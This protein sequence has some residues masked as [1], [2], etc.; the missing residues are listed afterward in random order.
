MSADPTISVVIP[1]YNAARWIGET[2]ESVLAQTYQDFEVIV[3]DDGSTDETAAVVGEF[4]GRVRCIQQPNRGQ[5]SARNAGIRAARGE[6][7]AFLDADDLWL[8]EKLH[9]QVGLLK[10]S[11][12]AWVYSDAIAFDNQTGRVLFRFGQVDRQYA[13][14]ILELLFFTDFIPSPTPVIRKSVFEQ[15]GCFDEHKTVQNRE[16]WAM[17]LRI[18]AC[19]PVGL[20]P[21]PLAEYRVHPTSMTGAE[22]PLIRLNG[23]LAVIEIAVAREP[24]RLG[25]YRSQVISKHH[26]IVGKSYAGMGQTK[27]ARAMF[28][29]AILYDPGRA[30]GYVFWLSTWLGPKF[31][32][33]LHRINVARRGY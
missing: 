27:A 2:L 16:D 26:L 5:A 33:G 23:H 20:T 19:Y 30:A 12:L 21:E 10:S 28:S 4:G 13:G 9:I 25:R 1:A 6:Y 3:V 32:R 31:L 14:D 11:G 29:T 18:A 22:D 15:V 8:K 24:L 7:I 17:W